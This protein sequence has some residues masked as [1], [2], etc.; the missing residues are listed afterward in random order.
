MKPDRNQMKLVT[1]TKHSTKAGSSFFRKPLFFIPSFDCFCGHFSF[2]GSTTIPL[3][4]TGSSL[5]ILKTLPVTLFLINHCTPHFAWLPV[6]QGTLTFSPGQG[7]WK[8]SMMERKDT[9]IDDK[10]A[11]RSQPGGY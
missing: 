8:P 7:C 3:K 2:S 10:Q 5:L 9:F 6:S 4:T 11:G 1:K